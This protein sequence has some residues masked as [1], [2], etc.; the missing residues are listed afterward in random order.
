VDRLTAHPEEADPPMRM[1]RKDFLVTAAGVAAPVATP[2]A[3][4]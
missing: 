4:K 3:A 2:A 1:K